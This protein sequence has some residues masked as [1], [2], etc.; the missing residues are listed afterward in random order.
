L[1]T[2]ASTTDSRAPHA[3]IVMTAREVEER[4]PRAPAQIFGADG[5]A[6]A[7]PSSIPGL[8]A[9]KKWQGVAPKWR[10]WMYHGMRWALGAVAACVT[11]LLAS[12]GF[13]GPAP[14]VPSEGPPVVIRADVDQLEPDRLVIRGTNFGDSSP[15]IVLL[16]Q[17]PLK[18][19][20]FSNEQ[21]VARLPLDAPPA[22][23]RLQVLVH[24]ASAWSFVDMTH[25]RRPGR[26]S[27]V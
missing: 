5:L 15:P 21:I 1:K 9:W 18:V 26:R 22:R 27:E 12:S 8:G 2:R 6:L 19:L 16:S 20:S 10:S 7:L 13:A 11:S 14:V 4:A 25:G 24:G 3:V 23:Y 17:I